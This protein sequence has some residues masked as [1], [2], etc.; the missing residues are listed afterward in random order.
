M[1]QT[2]KA[3]YLL[4]VRLAND[5]DAARGD[6]VGGV[7]DL[8]RLIGERQRALQTR[9]HLKRREHAL[10]ALDWL[11]RQRQRHMSAHY[12]EHANSRVPSEGR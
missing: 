1:M 12:C 8:L 10:L 11:Q 6:R 4:F 5:G 2:Q 7:D 9:R 3:A